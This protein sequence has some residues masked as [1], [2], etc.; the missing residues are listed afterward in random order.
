[1]TFPLEIR[2]KKDRLCRNHG[3]MKIESQKMS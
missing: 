1:M 3:D 2:Y